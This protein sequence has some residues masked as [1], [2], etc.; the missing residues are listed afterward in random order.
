MSIDPKYLDDAWPHHQWRAHAAA[1]IQADLAIGELQAIQQATARQH[2]KRR[3]QQRIDAMQAS[4]WPLGPYHDERWPE[5][6]AQTQYQTLKADD[7]LTADELREALDG[8]SRL[9]IVKHLEA[10]LRGTDHRSIANDDVPI[11]GEKLKLRKELA[12]VFAR[13]IVGLS[14]MG[15]IRSCIEAVCEYAI[16]HDVTVWEAARMVS[17]TE[18]AETQADDIE[19]TRIEYD[20]EWDG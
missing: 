2:L 15:L 16:Q 9:T 10:R 3:I 6:T 14:K 1:V 13:D 4:S 8:T 12:V 11:Y 19:D 7:T 20:D 17:S 18:T 5:G